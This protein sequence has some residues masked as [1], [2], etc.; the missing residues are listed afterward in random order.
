MEQA[1]YQTNRKACPY[2][3]WVDVVDGQDSVYY[4]QNWNSQTRVSVLSTFING[5][6]LIHCNQT[7]AIVIYRAGKMSPCS[8]LPAV[9]YSCRVGSGLDSE[10]N[11]QKISQLIIIIVLFC[12][13]RI[14]FTITPFFFF[15]CRDC[16]IVSK[17]GLF[18][19]P[20]GYWCALHLVLSST[21]TLLHFYYGFS[22]LI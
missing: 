13:Q 10:F 8:A 2:F 15:R 16:Y 22:L 1:Q 11:V 7:L 5:F 19:F 12:L 9:C 3:S 20:C 6:D 4:P 18:L 21:G 14:Q 17:L